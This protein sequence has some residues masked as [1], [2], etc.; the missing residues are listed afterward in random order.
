MAF[1][2][3]ACSKPRPKPAV[4]PLTE[5]IKET[6]QAKVVKN[7]HSY[8]LKPALCKDTQQFIATEIPVS[9]PAPEK[10]IKLNLQ[11]FSPSFS[12][13]IPFSSTLNGL[14]V[15]FDVNSSAINPCEAKKLDQFV[16]KI[17]PGAEIKIT[18]Y[19]CRLGS[20]EYN[21][22]LAMDRAKSISQ[23][24][25]NRGVHVQ[26]ASGKAGCCYI[27]D[28]DPA[29]NRRVEIQVLLPDHSTIL[30]TNMRKEVVKENNK[31]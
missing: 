21:Q 2:I 7:Q 26:T 23:F 18:G 28:T 8:N 1:S 3:V 17:S 20:V 9:I 19:T 5:V 12:S 29:K 15:F 25:S 24:L 22:K 10:A 6:Y 31:Q 4:L 27:S 13:K 30:N 16:K 11:K 14:T